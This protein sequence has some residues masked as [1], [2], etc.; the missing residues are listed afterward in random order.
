M[1]ILVLHAYITNTADKYMI[2]K[3]NHGNKK[4]LL[5]ADVNREK[6]AAS[7]GALQLYQEG[8]KSEWG[9]FKFLGIMK[10]WVPST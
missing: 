8:R 7:Y 2:I 4:L 3:S 9:I 5:T 6:K 10:P 1:F